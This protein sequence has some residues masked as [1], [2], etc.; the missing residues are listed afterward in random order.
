MGRERAFVSVIVP[1]C[2]RLAG[3]ARCLQALA[4]QTYPADQMEVILV[5]DGSDGDVETAVFSLTLPFPVHCIRQS[6][7]GPAAARNTGARRARGQLLAFTDDDCEPAPNWLTQLVSAH[8]HHPVAMLGG[9]TINANADNLYAAAS[10]M[11]TNFVSQHSRHDPTQPPFFPSNNIAIPRQQFWQ[12][13]GFDETM[14]LAAGEDR[15]FCAHWIQQGWPLVFVPDAVVQHRQLLNGWSFWQQQWRY[16]RGAWQWRQ[17]YAGERGR[18][19]AN[20]R[21]YWQ[22][23]RY[24][25]TA[26]TGPQRLPLTILFLIAQIAVGTG[27]TYEK[28]KR[29]SPSSEGPA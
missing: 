6:R 22:L 9:H 23:I 7:R 8:Y 15:A 20:W 21:F 24:P 10:Q 16:G 26:V 11:L 17:R 19:V 1:T 25:G 28:L 12:A 2:G 14:P 29:K 27:Y 13:G 3:I 4:R 5:D 18:K